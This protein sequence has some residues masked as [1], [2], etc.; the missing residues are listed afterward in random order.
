MDSEPELKSEPLVKN[1]TVLILTHGA[2]GVVVDVPGD[3][4]EGSNEPLTQ[5]RV[6]TIVHGYL[7]CDR[8]DLR[9]VST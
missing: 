1:D 4:V 6:A 8:E 5:Y 3:N 9:Y 2:L 7:L